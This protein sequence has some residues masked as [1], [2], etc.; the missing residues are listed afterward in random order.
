[1][2]APVET[3]TRYE[4]ATDGMVAEETAEETV[5]SNGIIIGEG[6]AASD[7]ITRRSGVVDG[8]EASVGVLAEEIFAEETTASDGL[9]LGSFPSKYRLLI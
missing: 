8:T 5:H 9:K 6:I 4:I 3:P 7:Q 1:M 2:N